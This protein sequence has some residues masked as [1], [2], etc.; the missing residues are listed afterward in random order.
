LWPNLAWWAA[1]AAGYR[2]FRAALV[3]PAAAQERV[4][5]RILRRNAD[6]VFGR[7]HRFSETHSSAAYRARVPPSVHDDYAP[8]IRRVMTGERAV[9]TRE[10]VRRLMPTGGSTAP[11]KLIPYTASLQK[12][13]QAAIAPWVFDLYRRQPGLLAGPAYWSISPALAPPKVDSA[14]PVGYESDT[15][16]LGGLCKPL[17]DR[18][19]AVPAAVSRIHDV[20]SFSR[21]TLVALL[22]ARELRLISIWHPSFLTRLLERLEP[23]WDRLLAALSDPERVRELRAGGPREYRRIWPRLGLISCWAHGFAEPYVAGVSQLFPHARIQPKGLLATE[24]FVSVPVGEALPIAVCSHFFEFLC[25]GGRTHLAHELEPGGTYCVVVTTGGGLYRYRLQDRVQVD[26]FIGRTPSVRFV[27][28]EDHLADAFGEKLSEGFVAEVLRRL[29]GELR[30]A[31]RFA[32]LARESTPAGVGYTLF[33]ETDEPLPPVLAGK[34]EAAL[35][36]N[37]NYRHCVALGQLTRARVQRIGGDGYATYV[38][39]C[40]GRGQ[41]LGDIK[42]VP[43]SNLSGWSDLFRPV[44]E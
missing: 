35:G 43:I 11:A 41:R 15:A 21:A 36:E 8:L 37:P 44:A 9:L 2:R 23:W 32:M 5:S 6:T 17:V 39:R 31:P 1:Q 7:Q 16:Y 20:Q 34:L 30:L 33:T 38:E 22:A 28:K 18:T 13:F 27:G 26:G 29:F 14:V 42:P 25:D 19:L 10:P 3:E 40:R 4:L 12:E 24:A